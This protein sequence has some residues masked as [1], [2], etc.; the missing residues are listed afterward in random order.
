MTAM[1][2]STGKERGAGRRVLIIVENLPVPFDRRVWSEATSLKAAGYEVTVICPTAKH[3]ERRHEVLDGIEI[4]RHPLKE[5]QGAAGYLREYGVA[6]FHQL[7]LAF[8]VLRNGGVDVVHGCNP[9]DLIFLV[10]LALRPFGVRFLF[11]HHD[12][13]PELF[14]TKFER[15]GMLWRGTLLCERLTFRAAS[16]SIATNESYR[17]IA[18]HRGGM[19]PEDVFVVRSGPRL[20]RL[21]IRPPRPEL[22]RG[23]RHLIGYVGVIGHQEGLDLLLA[24]AHHLIRVMGRRDVHFGI[25]GGGP[26][27]ETVRRT[28]TDMCLSEHFTFTG[29]APE[30]VLLDTLNTA[31]I[32]VNPDRVTPMNDLST[33][34]KVMEY[35]TLCKPIVQ[36]DMKEGRASAGDASLYARPNDPVDFAEKIAE[37]LDDPEARDRMGR[38]GRERIESHLSWAHSEPK[39]LDAYDRLFE[40][41]ASRGARL[42]DPRGLGTATRGSR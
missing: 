25:V 30:E 12:I 3:Y 22:K 4:L 34:N 28:C 41:I 10:A 38:I 13:C 32:C 31:D 14:E 6:L 36:F 37:L 24:A 17:D 23:K 29:R 2:A 33:M 7:R 35:M 8:K 26:H 1:T 19:A 42:A 39:L 18:I 21:E 27:L 9:P 40:K 11:D 15:R 16:V 20:D 5:A